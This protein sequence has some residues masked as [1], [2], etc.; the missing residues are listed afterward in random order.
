MSMELST[1]NNSFV[2]NK[3]KNQ[4]WMFALFL[5]N[6]TNACWLKNILPKH[7]M[8][9]FGFVDTLKKFKSRFYII[10]FHSNSHIF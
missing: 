4:R 5:T 6:I 7:S 10:L 2:Y 8:E 3:A 1:F 9:I